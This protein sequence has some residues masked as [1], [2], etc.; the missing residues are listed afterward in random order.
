MPLPSPRF[1][2]AHGVLGLPNAV[3]IDRA[4]DEVFIRAVKSEFPNVLT[5]QLLP[6]DAPPT[7]PYL[8]LA[9]SS[10]QLAVS[11]AQADFQ[12]RFYAD[13]VDDFPRG[14]EFVERKLRAIRAGY[15]AAELLPAMVGLIATFHF[16][17]DEIDGMSPARY[18]QRNLL[19]TEIEPE[20]A[21]QDAVAKVALRVRDT[22]F[23]NLTLSNYEERR[24]E[25][26]VIL[27]LGPTRVRA[28]EGEIQEVGL[29]LVLDINNNLEARTKREDPVVTD[30]G[31]HAV[32]ELL[33]QI[34]GAVG[35]GFADTG[36]VS[37]EALSGTS[38]S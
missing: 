10:A 30:D 29:E 17:G 23:V 32:A 7:A 22:Y 24:I 4:R 1:I 27:G 33:R 25:R 6:P 2:Q 37:V 36:R 31:I 20:D 28:W 5:H 38:T 9:S 14:L 15:E 26:P 19:R 18:I 12:V 13:Y 8:V 35:P 34:G 3:P 11:V 16:A 21:L